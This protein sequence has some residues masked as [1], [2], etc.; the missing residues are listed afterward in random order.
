[1]RENPFKNLGI[2]ENP[3]MLA[4]LAGVS[5]H[6]FR[7]VCQELGADL[8]Y[9]EMIS[10][11][12]LTYHSQR[13]L[14]MLCRHKSESVL[15]VQITSRSSE[16]MAKAT[17]IMDPYPFDT[18]DINMGCPVKK[19]VKSGCGSAILKDPERV[20]Q[21]TLAA[22][23][24]TDKSVSV[25]IRLGWDHQSL[26]WREVSQAAQEAG[27][28]WLTVHGRTRSDSYGDPVNLEKIAELKA[29][30]DIPV[31]GNGNLFTK[32]DAALMKKATKVDGLMVSRGALG[33][34][35]VF[36]EIKGKRSATSLEE[37]YQTVSIH[38]DR[39]KEAYGDRGIGSVCMRK[40]ILW[41]VSGW[42]HARKIR[43]QIG[44]TESLSEVRTAL[45]EYVEQLRSEG[46]TQRYQTQQQSDDSSRFLW[47][48]VYDM[49]RSLDRGVGDDGLAN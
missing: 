29:S 34:P 15:G 5:D 2:P 17:A 12:A 28:K 48:P 44:N 14:D 38:I 16:E 32:D 46:V 7:R 25:K 27:A 49:D 22:C 19:V 35:W 4:P 18:I 41:Y 20:Y 47:N 33:N 3:V 10:A 26:T 37:W 39:Q 31:I 8:T 11:T 9:V 24:N 13:T 30:L 36:D 1:M 6:P 42:P 45:D 40:H 23:Q 43:E 21:T